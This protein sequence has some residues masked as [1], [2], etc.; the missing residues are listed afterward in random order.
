MNKIKKLEKVAISVKSLKILN[1]ILKENPKL[2]QI[3]RKANNK[4]E[5]LLGVKN[6]VLSYLNNR[7]K[8]VEFYQEDHN[9]REDFEELNWRDYGAIRL[10]DYIDN[11]G[12]KFND[13]NLR[14]D[15]VGSNPIKYIWMAVKFGTGGA[16]EDF[17]YDMLHLFRQFTGKSKKHIPSENQL[18][19][20][21]KRHP[22]GLDPKIV[23][24]REK[25]RD[26]ILNIF[27][28]GKTIH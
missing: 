22:S 1:Q 9:G 28:E 13:L 7:P 12:R 20:W 24:L 23:K 10:M 8:A 19:D 25:N 21:M 15:L 5:A 17:F 4:S 16:R 2:E 6:W 3:M 26:R 14:G 27:I 18:S 11:A